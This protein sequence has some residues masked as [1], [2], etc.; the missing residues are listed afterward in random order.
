MV[1][2]EGHV[3]ID[4]TAARAGL[5]DLAQ[6]M[7]EAGSLPP[8]VLPESRT[9]TEKASTDA[10]RSGTVAFMRNWPVAY[11]QLEEDQER[12]AGGA[13]DISKNFTVTRLPGPS[14]LGGQN[15]AVSSSTTKPRAARE[16]VEF[17]TS[18][19]SER[20]LFGDGGLPAT[21]GA[22][23]TDITVRKARPYADALLASL[24]NARPRPLTTYYTLFTSV[25]QD[26]VSEALAP[27]RS[28]AEQGRLPD[29]AVSRLTDALHG[30]LR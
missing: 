7:A 4:S 26:V 6:G 16:L 18:E 11:G 8:A 10:F 28:P 2:A 29:D 22:A 12:A 27:G 3:V 14:V 20:K 21:R 1:N 5:R 25:F 15:L 30:R 19:S 17:L 24:R 23:Y 13:F 9:F